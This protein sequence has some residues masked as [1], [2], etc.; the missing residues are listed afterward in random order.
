MPNNYVVMVLTDPTE[1]Q[2]E[3]FNDDY[4]NQDLEEVVQT[5]NFTSAHRFKLAASEGEESPLPYLAVYETTA[6]S[7]K[8]LHAEIHVGH[9]ASGLTHSLIGVGHEHG[10]A[11]AHIDEGGDHATVHLSVRVP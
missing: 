8:V 10:L 4:E 6:D 3:S 11:D 5:T 9:E 2:E 7:A 1:G